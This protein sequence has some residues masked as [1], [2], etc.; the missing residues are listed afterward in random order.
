MKFVKL[1]WILLNICTFAANAQ[2][3][4]QISQH[5]FNHLMTNPGFAGNSGLINL[6]LLN[7]QQWV[8]FPGAPATTVFQADAP[9][10]LIGEA[11]GLGFTVVKDEIGYEKNVSFGLSYSFRFQLG[12]GQLGCGASFGM[13]NK[14]LRPG[15]SGSQGGELI[16]GSDPSLPKQEVNG[17][18]TDV[19]VGF[20]YRQKKY[21]LAISSLHLN[22]PSFAFEENG[23]YS[24]KRHY[25]L[26]GGYNIE[27]ND[28][29]FAF[30]PSFFIKSDGTTSQLDLDLLLK[31]NKRFWGGIGY[32]NKDAVMLFLG[33]EM[34]NGLKIGYSY[35]LNTSILS[36]YNSGSHELFISYAV[37]LN[38]NRSQ[39]NK[40]VRFL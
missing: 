27:L 18:L 2:Q 13:M 21:Y 11:D 23:H 10:K 32:R 37:L 19:G 30:Q 12:Q 17:V 40:S 6:M 7:R 25:Y 4:P 28:D 39:K 8:G 20:F 22:Q 34:Q 31:Y 5:M 3:D 14:N 29:R 15:W 16:D 24:L 1:L 35:D 33:F 9:L 26:S 38:K 36:N